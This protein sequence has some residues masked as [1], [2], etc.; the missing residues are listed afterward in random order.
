[1]IH[2]CKIKRKSNALDFTVKS[3]VDL[4]DLKSVVK[5]IIDLT[6]FFFCC[7]LVSMAVWQTI[8]SLHNHQHN[9]ILTSIRTCAGLSQPLVSISRLKPIKSC[10]RKFASNSCLQLPRYFGRRDHKQKDLT[11]FMNTASAD[12]PFPPQNILICDHI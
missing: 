4:I 6:C 11:S 12:Y 3:R 8:I 5:S 1:M 9:K 7:T 2:N 10:S